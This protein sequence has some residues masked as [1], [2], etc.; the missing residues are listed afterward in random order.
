[1]PATTDVDIESLIRQSI[2]PEKALLALPVQGFSFFA[3]HPLL[4][5]LEAPKERR[6]FKAHC[7]EKGENRLTLTVHWNMG[8]VP[9]GYHGHWVKEDSIWKCHLMEPLVD[10]LA[11]WQEIKVQHAPHPLYQDIHEPPLSFLQAFSGYI[12]KRWSFRPWPNRAVAK[13]LILCEEA[14]ST[15]KSDEILKSL[16][17]L[18]QQVLGWLSEKRFMER[19]SSLVWLLCHWGDHQ[20]AHEFQTYCVEKW[21]KGAPEHSLKCVQEARQFIAEKSVGWRLVWI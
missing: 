13:A 20:F 21:I 1:M 16:S 11:W 12:P 2:I 4:R 3:F 17:I 15:G 9:Y 19:D 5:W 14:F 10:D 6:L 8:D 18:M 7:E